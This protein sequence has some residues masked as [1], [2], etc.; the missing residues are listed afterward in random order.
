MVSGDIC[1]PAPSPETVAELVE[2][3]AGLAI[4]NGLAAFE[5]DDCGEDA[6]DEVS[7]LMASSAEAAAP[8]ANSIAKL[9]QLPRRAVNIPS[10]V[11]EQ[12]PC[13]D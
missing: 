3:E 5:L 6:L 13:H 9:R 7:A 10:P 8:R 1:E 11:H 2:A 12:T 4:S